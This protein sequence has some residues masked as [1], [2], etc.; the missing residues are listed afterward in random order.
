MGDIEVGNQV[1]RPSKWIYALVKLKE[2]KFN[3]V[4]NAGK[5]SRTNLGI[6]GKWGRVTPS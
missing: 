1:E 6:F 3:V 4:K 5:W 2:D